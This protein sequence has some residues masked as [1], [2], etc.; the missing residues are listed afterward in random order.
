MSNL[1]LVDRI[2]RLNMIIQNQFSTMN[3]GYVRVVC[4]TDVLQRNYEVTQ[5]NGSQEI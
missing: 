3:A 2:D 5:C 1:T 4:S